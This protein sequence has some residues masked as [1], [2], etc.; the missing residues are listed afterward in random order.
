MSAIVGLIA[1]TDPLSIDLLKRMVVSG[2]HRG[3]HVATAKYMGQ[4]ALG[5]AEL[6]ITREDFQN[7]Q[8]LSIDG[9]LSWVVMDG[10]LDNRDELLDLLAVKPK[11][12]SISDCQLTAMAYQRWGERCFEKL[13]GNFAIIIWDDRVKSMLCAV[14]HLATRPLFYSLSTE[15]FAI[16]STIKQIL[17]IPN[18][19]GEIDDTFIMA[20]LCL[21]STLPH[22]TSLTPYT[23]IRRLL[24][25]HVITIDIDGRQHTTRYWRPE[26]L[27]VLYSSP[28]PEIIE[29]V[30]TT[31]KEVVRSQSRSCATVMSTL[32]GGLDSSSIACMAALLQ[33]ESGLLCENFRCISETY[34]TGTSADEASFRR[35][36]IDM[37]N[38]EL[39][40]FSRDYQGHAG[41]LKD[42]TS[43]EADEPFG[44]YLMSAKMQMC[45]DI[46]W[47]FGCNVL[48]FG[49]GGDELMQGTPY[50]LGDY[51]RQ[52]KIKDLI[53]GIWSESRVPNLNI[54]SSILRYG[55]LP[56]MPTP[57]LRLG[58]NKRGNSPWD[59]E[60]E[61]CNP[62]VPPWL[63]VQRCIKLGVFD[64]VWKEFPE[65]YTSLPSRA[66]QLAWLRQNNFSLWLDNYVF[67]PKGCE[68]R[69]PFMDKRFIELALM[70]PSQWK[71][72][73]DTDGTVV[74]KIILREAMHGILP[75]AIRTRRDRANFG[76]DLA[77]SLRCELLKLLNSRTWEVVDRGYVEQCRLEQF[78]KSWQI[79]IWDFLPQMCSLLSTESWL[80]Q[81]NVSSRKL[82]WEVRQMDLVHFV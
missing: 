78:I 77:L 6:K 37:Y 50:Y 38:L 18:T 10:R 42:D 4:V 12:S 63:S 44:E 67:M 82:G 9:G 7:D 75:E 65:R 62:Q 36:V 54:F 81:T 79:G 68:T 17:Q 29:R 1:F 14:D 21:Q 43:L 8:P 23:S 76:G 11:Q 56:I 52:L 64:R 74:T 57:F 70:I 30:R 53:S 2:M 22:P 3:G 25:G 58:I 32:S 41:D 24:P 20:N 39:T 28:R 66:Q 40:E 51:L 34:K 31:F 55:I 19:S 35:A 45:A 15:K 72:G 46:A 69:M 26:E 49:F 13:V 71:K 73:F 80:R 33:S 61:W 47:R 5:C 16:A 48:I 60:T 27:P 59:S